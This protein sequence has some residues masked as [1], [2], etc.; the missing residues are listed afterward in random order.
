MLKKL[1]LVTGVMIL[2]SCIFIYALRNSRLKEI[3][4]ELNC[5]ITLS[6]RV[7]CAD[8]GQTIP[9]A[10]LLIDSSQRAF[11]T[12]SIGQFVIDNLCSG[13]VL[14]H[15]SFVGYKTLDTTLILTKNKQIDFYM[16]PSSIHLHE[17][18][19]Q[20]NA[21][22][23][24]EV[25]SVTKT[26]L[27]GLE[28]LKTRGVDLGDA[29]KDIS[30]VDVIHTGPTIAKPVIHG[31]H[32][33]R[34]LILNNGVRQEGQQW[35]SEHAPEIDPFIATKLSVLKGAASIRYGSDAIGGVVMVEPND[36]P[37]GKCMDGEL[38][39]VG[40][41][42][43]RMETASG[44]IQ[45]GFDNGLSY[46]FQGTYRRAGNVETPNYI[47]DNTALLERNYSAAIGYNKE[48]YGL[49]VYYSH[50]NTQL[51]VFTYSDA[52]NPTQLQELFAESKP[53]NFPLSYYLNRPGGYYAINRGYQLVDHD[54]FKASGYLKYGS[55]GKL[56]ATFA[57][58]TDMR[59]EYSLDPPYVGPG[60]NPDNVP[61]NNFDLITHTA[62]L[63]FE[64]N[65]WHNITGSIGSS[66]ITQ[67]NVYTGTSFAPVIPNFR[68][69]GGGLYW[70]EKW[71]PNT[72]FTLE[73]GIRY[74]YKWQR[75]YQIDQTTV[76]QYLTT[77]QYNSSTATI[78]AIYRFTP[79]LSVNLNVGNGW[80]APSVYE[81]YAY[82]I[83]GATST[84]E[85]GDSLLNVE[86]A[87]NS[88]AS[89]RY[90]SDELEIEFGGYANL[91]D[92]YMYAK[93]T[94]TY[95]TTIIGTFPVF[96]F[97][98][99]N[100]LFKGVDLDAKWHISK[101]LTFEPKMTLV[102]AND[103]TNHDYLVLVP[104]Q[105]FQNSMSYKWKKLGH[106]K[107]VFI[108]VGS[109]IVFRQ[110]RVPPNSDF[111]PP[112][113]GYSLL[114]AGIGCSI[115]FG[116][117]DLNI[118]IQGNNLMNTVY[119]DYLDYFR[120]YADEPGRSILLRVQIP[121]TIIPNKVQQINN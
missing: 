29:L 55:F 52:S 83:H 99:T 28:L 97:T 94:L 10:T 72:S 104:P 91:I 39:L 92:N 47:L 59:Q 43:S 75:E 86:K 19:V 33:N 41:D 24:Q 70:I 76:Q 3:E 102:F 13:N 105:R 9:G 25:E 61:E 115:P 18:Q 98:Q 106:L 103:L 64:H 60:V 119:R 46:R 88:T 58:Q 110:T 36:L 26:E 7:I 11:Q 45:G 116:K 38:N 12:D 69:Y 79:K 114:L 15:I 65:D 66:F 34:V 62:E 77:Q 50:F 51:G 68:N 21:V 118:S 31:L 1:F 73:G 90:E 82:G 67:G 54:L 16:H 100:A 74:D 22:K 2:V 8:D 93:P 96:Q 44:I 57:R 56:E 17:F 81:L 37:K 80:R 35:G 53:I 5:N 14:L 63:I 107:N 48:H 113:D 42:N 40:M 120:Y 20:A 71:N 112:P 89:L 32:S 78:G 30:G 4:G 27:T 95:H 6:G 117:R 109:A 111:V 84:W 85:Q 121:F 108:N 101:H 23:K 49:N 87:Y